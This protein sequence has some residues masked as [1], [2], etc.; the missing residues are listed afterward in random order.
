MNRARKVRLEVVRLAT[1]KQP[2]EYMKT[3][4]SKGIYFSMISTGLSSRSYSNQGVGAVARGL[5]VGI[6]VAT[7]CLDRL[8]LKTLIPNPFCSNLTSSIAKRYDLDNARRLERE[9]SL[10]ISLESGNAACIIN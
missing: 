3:I 9:E 6:S 4:I 7:H 2:G 8:H 1:I 10:K 5:A